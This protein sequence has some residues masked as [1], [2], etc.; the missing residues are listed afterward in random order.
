MTKVGEVDTTSLRNDGTTAY[1]SYDSKKGQI[2]AYFDAF[3]RE[4]M[5][6]KS[7]RRV[8]IKGERFNNT[9]HS[10]ISKNIIKP[11]FISKDWRHRIRIKNSKVFNVK[12]KDKY[13]IHWGDLIHEIMAAI[14]S[15]SDIDSVLEYF[16]IKKQYGIST[17]NN[18]NLQITRIMN[19]KK[20][21][22]LL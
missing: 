3:L 20:V 1:T 5:T 12:F 8:F 13:S 10:E 2:Y 21:K 6:S 7:T 4:K 18:M 17:F 11:V 15:K 19:N 14:K 16:S 9:G 22:H